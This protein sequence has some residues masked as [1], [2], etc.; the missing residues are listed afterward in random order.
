MNGSD[1]RETPAPRPDVPPT[2]AALR[3][4]IKAAPFASVVFAVGSMVYG[5]LMFLKG[6]ETIWPAVWGFLIPAL[7]APAGLAVQ[8]LLVKAIPSRYETEEYD[9]PD[10]SSFL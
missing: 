7:S 5:L 3:F 2:I 9:E 10:E 6:D 4:M 8:Y 1:S